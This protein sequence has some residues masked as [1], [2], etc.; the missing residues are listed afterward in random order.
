M[1]ILSK[2]QLQNDASNEAHR[3][4]FKRNILSEAKLSKLT[5][6]GHDLGHFLRKSSSFSMDIDLQIF[7]ISSKEKQ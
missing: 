2:S 5:K 6:T 1:K 3:Y 4:I 7:D